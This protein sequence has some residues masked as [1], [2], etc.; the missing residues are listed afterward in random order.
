MN[1]SLFGRMMTMRHEAILIAVCISAGSSV[2]AAQGIGG[3]VKDTGLVDA[4]FALMETAAATL[5]REEP[6]EVGSTAPWQNPET[7]AA[8]VP[9]NFQI[10][11]VVDVHGQKIQVGAGLR[12]WIAAPNSGP[13][14]ISARLNFALLF[15]R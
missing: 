15:P 2:V 11:Q 10:N 14:G 6:R 4:D 3:L 9:V 8:S 13:E 1:S 7:G 12:Y 5:Y